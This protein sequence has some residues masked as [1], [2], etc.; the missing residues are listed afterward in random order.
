MNTDNRI[1]N[2]FRHFYRSL[3]VINWQRWLTFSVIYALMPGLNGILA[4]G[5]PIY[6][7][8]LTTMAWRA[9]SRVQFFGVKRSNIKTMVK[10]CLTLHLLFII[11][12]NPF[13][14]VT[15]TSLTINCSFERRINHILSLRSCG[16]GLNC[17]VALEAFALSYLTLYSDFIISIA[18]YLILRYVHN[19]HIYVCMCVYIL[20]KDRWLYDNF[21]KTIIT[22][23]FIL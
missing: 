3:S 15:F 13:K 22:I 4:I 7:V 20:L 18:H 10:R 17:A 16:R 8:L 14:Y 6:T 5:V 1:V 23:D 19:V 11:S 2:F 21:I 9:I 12:F